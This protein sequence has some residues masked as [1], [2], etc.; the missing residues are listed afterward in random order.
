MKMRTLSLAYCLFCCLALSA[1]NGIVEPFKSESIL[2]DFGGHTF[3]NIFFTDDSE[4]TLFIDFEV[5]ADELLEL[6]IWKSGNLMM[7]DDISDLPGDAIYELNLDVIRKGTYTI[8]LVT[9]F[10]IKIQKEIVIK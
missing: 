8:E 5:V 6:N 1:N 9:E 4:K 7:E 3:Y 2:N 10:G